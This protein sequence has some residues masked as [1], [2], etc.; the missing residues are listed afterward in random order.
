MTKQFLNFWNCRGVS[1]SFGR[2]STSAGFHCQPA[3]AM[4]HFGG[5]MIFWR[6]EVNQMVNNIA[7]EVI[8]PF[9]RGKIAGFL[10]PGL[11]IEKLKKKKQPQSCFAKA[12]IIVWKFNS[13]NETGKLQ[14]YKHHQ[15]SPTLTLLTT[16]SSIIIIC[17][18]EKHTW[19]KNKTGQNLSSSKVI[20]SPSAMAS[21]KPNGQLNVWDP[22][23]TF[24]GAQKQKAENLEGLSQKTPG[25]ILLEDFDV[26]LYI[27]GYSFK[28]FK[29]PKRC[30]SHD[31]CLEFSGDLGVSIEG[32]LWHC[33]LFRK[34]LLKV[35][36]PRRVFFW[37][38]GRWI[39]H[40][41]KYLEWIESSCLVLVNKIFQLNSH[42]K[43]WY[44]WHS[45]QWF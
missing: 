41:W 17:T 39:L 35:S 11:R 38:L 6:G 30:P 29:V 40:P 4:G 27:K 23:T 12:N 2:S 42:W 33:I 9:G 13:K 3:G 43:F 16:N 1:T 10:L 7:L 24:K 37:C 25:R 32:G 44:C 36:A 19:A 34:S 21:V 5:S 31:F 22:N 8:I 26:S 18:F 45:W 28:D 14:S 15:V 20:S